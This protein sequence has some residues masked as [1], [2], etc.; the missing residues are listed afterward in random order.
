[1]SV[2]GSCGQLVAW[3][4]MGS[5]A[6]GVPLIGLS[7]VKSESLAR[8]GVMP[9][10]LC[11]NIDAALLVCLCFVWVARLAVVVCPMWSCSMMTLV[12]CTGFWPVSLQMNLL[13]LFY[14]FNNKHGGPHKCEGIICSWLSVLKKK[15]PSSISHYFL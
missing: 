10:T 13:I 4:D 2:L 15:M 5:G 11:S 12:H 9:M 3:A 1:M 7:P 6:V 8:G 14:F